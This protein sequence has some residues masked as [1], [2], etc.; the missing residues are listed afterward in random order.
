MGFVNR[1]LKENEKRQYQLEY[2]RCNLKF[3]D[4]IYK[5]D[6]GTIDDENDIRI[7]IYGDAMISGPDYRELNDQHIKYGL[8]DYKNE[9]LYFTVRKTY[10][11]GD[12]VYWSIDQKEWLSELDAEKINILKDALYIYHD[13]GYNFRSLMKKQ[14]DSEY[15]LPNDR[16]D[17][18]VDFDN[19]GECCK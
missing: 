18:Y 10:R 9:V 16:G 4:K 11:N 17:V 13:E 8:M 19:Q 5:F 7:F 15:R 1:E 3:R 12:D 2:P 14:K 6:G